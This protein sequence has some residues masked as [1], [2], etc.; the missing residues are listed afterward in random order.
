MET[1]GT[2][3]CW[4]VL[5]DQKEHHDHEVLRFLAMA[6]MALVNVL[7]QLAP[8][9]NGTDPYYLSC[10]HWSSLK[11]GLVLFNL[12]VLVVSLRGREDFQIM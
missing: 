8:P 3:G 10:Y 2:Y 11:Y 4:Y 12:V 6:M 5:L 1:R 7:S 9:S